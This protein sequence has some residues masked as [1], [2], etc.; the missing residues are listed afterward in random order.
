[1]TIV[2]DTETTGLDA[3]RDGLIEFAAVAVT[4]GRITSEFSSL[5]WPGREFLTPRH[6]EVLAISGI[7]LEDLLDAPGAVH[8]SAEWR[9]WAR[10]LEPPPTR[11]TSFNV[12]F[13]RPFVEHWLG[14]L[15]SEPEWGPCLMLACQ[16]L[17][18]DVL[19]RR[20]DG[21]IRYP[22]LSAACAHLGIPVATTHRA[23]D[24]ARAAA[25]IAIALQER[26]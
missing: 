18:A 19:E 3:L 15:S 17:M 9:E 5:V 13:D 21:S 26:Q 10:H 23:L 11:V 7:T 2:V 12:S 8:V 20:Y 14:C 22:K 6:R 4:S 1:M 24:D 16:E 25:R